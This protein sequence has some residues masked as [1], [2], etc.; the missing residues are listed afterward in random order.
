[1]LVLVSLYKIRSLL[2]GDLRL[3]TACDLRLVDSTGEVA[4]R[5]PEGFALPSLA[6]LEADLPDAIAACKDR[7]AGVTTVA[8]TI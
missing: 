4:A 6:D 1:M 5:V 8:F 2:E 7:L 3:R